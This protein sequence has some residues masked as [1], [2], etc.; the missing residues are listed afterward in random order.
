MATTGLQ[1]DEALPLEIEAKLR[2]S[3]RVFRDLQRQEAFDGWQVTARRSLGLRDTYWDTP[4]RRLARAG[5]TL[6]VREERQGDLQRAELTLKGPVPDR[7]RVVPGRAASWSRTE[8]TVPVPA[9]SGPHE[10]SQLPGAEPVI[11]ALRGL[12]ALHGLRADVVL[13]NPR[14]ELILQQVGQE[15]SEAVLSLDEVRIEGQ[16]YRR[17]YVELELRRGSRPALDDLVALLVERFPLRPSR[18]GKVTAAR[19]WLQRRS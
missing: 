15:G 11:D 7:G 6:R 8:R 13:L 3:A 19:A 16:P 4:D 18:Q 10:W 1:Q 17:R 9:G 12:D 2:A 5:C 14:L